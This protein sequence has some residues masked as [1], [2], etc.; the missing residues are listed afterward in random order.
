MTWAE[1]TSVEVTSAATPLPDRQK[2]NTMALVVLGYPSLDAADFRYIQAFRADHDPL[3][4]IVA[5]H[6]TL[7]FP[8]EDLPE[9]MFVGH[10]RR[11]AKQQPPIEFVLRSVKVYLPHPGEKDAPIFLIPDEGYGALLQLHNRLYSGPIASS[12]R[13]DMAFIPHITIG[14]KRDQAAA[15]RAVAEFGPQGFAM[16]GTLARLTVARYANGLVTN[17][18][19]V[20][21]QG[22]TMETI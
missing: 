20:L 12:A 15:H 11:I 21:L 6:F 7:V 2:G 1:M 17:L 9:D 18:V 3:F 4:R 14:R 22:S 19:E 13:H 5:P 10:V 8:V 16:P